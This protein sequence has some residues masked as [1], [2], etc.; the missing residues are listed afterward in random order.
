M[1]KAEVLEFCRQGERVCPKPNRWM[2]M[3]DILARFQ[4]ASPP[5]PPLILGGW[6]FSSNLEKIVRLK[7]QIEWANAHGC[8]EEVG[9]FLGG[10]GEEEWHHLTEGHS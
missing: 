5:P 10:L 1:T 3:A 4:R 8:V 6:N 2:A 9:A 7:E